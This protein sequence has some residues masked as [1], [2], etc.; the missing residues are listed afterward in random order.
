MT[1]LGINRQPCFYEDADYAYYLEC[2]YDAAQ[3]WRCQ[4]HA[5]ALLPNHVHILMTPTLENGMARTLQSL[6]RR[7]VHYINTKYE[8]KG[9]LWA[10]RHN[11]SL[12]EADYILACYNYIEMMPVYVD[13]VSR[14]SQYP[15]SSFNDHTNGSKHYILEDHQAYGA[16]AKTAPERK[17]NYI[18]YV[19]SE[20]KIAHTDA[21]RKA[22]RY[23]Q[24]IG[25][26]HFKQTLEKKLARSLSPGRR[27][28]PKKKTTG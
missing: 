20:K 28:R 15:W 3:K 10:G 22:I 18:Q 7:Y 26:E 11:A 23:G 17:A 6:N 19:Q 9:T 13:L 14:P 1:Q 8:R 24:V 25:S 12:V 27:G 16:L 4:I 2:L 5:Y 21:I